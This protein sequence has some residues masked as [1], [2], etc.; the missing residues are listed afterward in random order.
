[1]EHMIKF[2]ANFETAVRGLKLV[3]HGTAPFLWS[4]PKGLAS[5]PTSRSDMLESSV[6]DATI[7]IAPGYRQLALIGSTFTFGSNASS[8]ALIP[9]CSAE[10]PRLRHSFGSRRWSYSSSSP[11]AYRI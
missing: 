7:R 11:F 4:K 1:M 3:P 8:R 6:P 5:E 2:A 10:E 9:S